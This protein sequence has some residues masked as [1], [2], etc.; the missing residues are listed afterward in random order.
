MLH[1]NTVVCYFQEGDYFKF[2]KVFY[3]VTITNVFGT[4]K[5]V[6]LFCDTFLG[7]MYQQNEYCHSGK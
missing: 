7:T 4:L 3:D 2:R 5:L 1:I 6:S